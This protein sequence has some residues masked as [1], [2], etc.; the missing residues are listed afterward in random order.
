MSGQALI[1]YIGGH[2]TISHLVCIIGAFLLTFSRILGKDYFWVIDDL[3]GIARFS[4]R[5]QGENKDAAGKIIPE[6]KID[7]YEIGEGAAKK[8]VKFLSFI[9]E[10]G[11]PGCIL[12]FIRLHVGKRLQVIG[13]N[14]KG[15]P[16]WG[17]SQSP[18]RHHLLSMAVQ[19]ANLILAY[20]VFRPLVGA[21][22]AFGACMLYAVHPLV[23][24]T[25]AWI[26]GISYSL[27]LTFSLATLLTAINIHNYH[28]SIPLVVFLTFCSG[29][30]LYIGCFTW[31]I[32]LFLGLKWAAFA[33]GI[34]SFFV[35]LWKGTETKNFR[36]KSF[37]EQ[38]MDSTTFLSWRKPVVMVKT[39]L[40]YFKVIFLPLQMGLY[41]EWGYFYEE[42]IER[43]NA[44]FWWG[45][46]IVPGI[47]YLAWHTGIPGV[48]LGIVWF[49]SYFFLF[50]NFIT[51]QQFVADRYVAVPVLGICLILANLLYT[52]PFFWVIVGLYAMRTFMHLPAFKNEVDYYLSN[53]LNFRKSEVALGNLGV[54]YMN[55][56]MP[57]SAVDMWMM[58]TKVNPHYDVSWYNLYSIF[59]ANG[60]LQEA[61][62]FFRKVMDAKIV[63]FEDKWKKEL[64][65][66][67]RNMNGA[68]PPGGID[69]VEHTNQQWRKYGNR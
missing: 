49:F 13:T 1:S 35:L 23:T 45:L 57:G 5:W 16:V 37:K 11:F 48:Q 65:E 18:R 41:H 6:T 3:D 21:N 28:I 22:V 64:E 8:T 56:G 46:L 30:I 34:I 54:A 55:S 14:K 4:E 44:M 25:V 69:L 33:A 58:A 68:V 42:P 61:L 38:N 9:P 2:P 10:L 15:H 59:R 50:T 62:N 27:S 24:Q 20:F 67:E 32:L 36:V 29:V 43:V 12:R 26:S 39:L 31:I 51:A 53:F 60:R 47:T 7:S 63:H 66:F 52:T 40:Y 19:I 17:F